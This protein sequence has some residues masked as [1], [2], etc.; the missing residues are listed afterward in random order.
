MLL[1]PSKTT[2]IIRSESY[3][4]GSSQEISYELAMDELAMRVKL[5]SVQNSSSLNIDFENAMVKFYWHIA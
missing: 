5:Y 4:W 1:H 3:T 2:K